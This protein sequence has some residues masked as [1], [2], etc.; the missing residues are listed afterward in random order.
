MELAEVAG[1][2]RRLMDQHGLESWELAFDHAR[3]R[4]GACHYT[5][6]KITVSRHLMVLYDESSVAD[7]LLHEIAHA[8]AG[9]RAGHGPRWK[10]TAL[11]IGG[12]GTR[13]AGREE[14]RVPSPWVGVCSGGHEI[15]R[16]RLP[17]HEASCLRCSP[18]FD[19]RFLITWVRREDRAAA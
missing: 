1:L 13:L 9:P 6:Q 11:R 7:T 17:R 5:A 18:T 8:L 19:R 15:D 10:A 14:P 2:G 16:F 12:S 4:A 3:R